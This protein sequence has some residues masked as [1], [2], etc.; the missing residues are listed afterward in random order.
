MRGCAL[1]PY[2]YMS[3]LPGLEKPCSGRLYRDRLP[4]FFVVDVHGA[5]K[6]GIE[7]V[8]RPQD[9]QRLFRESATGLSISEASYG[10]GVPS[11]ERGPAFQVDGT[12]H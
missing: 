4:R 11:S 8:D 5:G 2:H 9:F 1:I 7:G 6:T 3:V 12:T 10:P